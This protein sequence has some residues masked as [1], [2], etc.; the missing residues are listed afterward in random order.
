MKKLEIITLDQMNRDS[1]SNDSVFVNLVFIY[2]PIIQ[3]LKK[4]NITFNTLKLYI[5]LKK[6]NQ[7][8]VLISLMRLYGIPQSLIEDNV[9]TISYS[10]SEIELHF[11]EESVPFRGECISENYSYD[12]S[13]DSLLITKKPFDEKCP[14][15][16][17]PEGDGLFY[18]DLDKKES[19]DQDRQSI[20]GDPKEIYAIVEF[21]EA[22]RNG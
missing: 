16:V 1:L 11:T 15:I 3:Q 21:L 12:F 2:E 19:Q 13:S 7:R 5:S 4:Y 14:V 22:Q 17:V 10:D 8:D 9:F 18:R 20:I 6:Y